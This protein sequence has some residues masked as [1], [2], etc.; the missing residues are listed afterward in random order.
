LHKH[1]VTDLQAMITQ[2]N[3][4]SAGNKHEIVDRPFQ[5]WLNLQNPGVGHVPLGDL[6]VG[7]TSSVRC[8]LPEHTQIANVVQKKFRKAVAEPKVFWAPTIDPDEL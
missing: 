1:N 4:S 6:T 5:F 3:L 7:P 8:Q 2:L